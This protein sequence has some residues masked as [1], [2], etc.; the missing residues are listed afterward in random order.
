MVLT[1]CL[2]TKQDVCA[3]TAACLMSVMGKTIEGHAVSPQIAMGQSD[4]PKARSEQVSTWFEQA[5]PGDLFL[6]LDSDQ[7][8]TEKDLETSIYYLSEA[9]VVCGAYPRKNGTMTVQPINLVSFYRERHGP[10]WFGS[11]GFMAFTYETI[12]KIIQE[13]V[14]DP[15]FISQGEKKTYPLFLERIVDEPEL[16]LKSLWLGEDFSFCWVARQCGIPI[17]GY[18]S[19]T[20]GHILPIERFVTPPST[21]VWPEKSIVYY[22]GNTSEPWSGKSIEKGIGGSETA[23]IKLSEEWVKKGY[24]VTVFCNCDS[25]GM[26]RGVQYCH[27]SE[28]NVTDRFDIFI[29][30][31]AIHVYNYFDIQA[32]V[33]LLDLHDIVSPAQITERVWKNVSKIC[34]KSGYHAGLLG[35][36]QDKVAKV[37]IIPNG[38]AEMFPNTAE[39]RDP[40]YVIYAS[41]YDRGL[42]YILKWAWPKIRQSCPN[43]Y[44][45]IFYGWNG[46]D[47]SQPKTKDVQLYKDTVLE[48]MSQEGVQECG[49]IPREQLLAEKRKANVHLYT[50]DFQEIDCISVRESACMGAIPVVSKQVQVFGEKKYCI[51][52]DGDPHT[53]SMQEKAAEMVS[54]LI[55]DISYANGVRKRIV[56]SI[57]DETWE[58]VA[59]E[60]EKV[61]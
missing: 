44:L 21:F 2:M 20:I 31:R 4:L 27:H 60:W 26:Y 14:R 53:Q 15:V 32:R 51:L 11:T 40:N 49:R 48:L 38:G 22:C 56:Q 59:K 55:R 5:R 47:A 35:N 36:T 39:E 10:L 28:F 41:S 23:V 45:K 18:I 19:P 46:F 37:A 58:T 8:F 57:P 12:Q 34:V 50:G 33:A 52:V 30:W 61:F 54:T 9:G 3:L 6:F 29:S 24:R 43:A 17:H 1:I 13:Y 42:P 25:P 7:T 16:G